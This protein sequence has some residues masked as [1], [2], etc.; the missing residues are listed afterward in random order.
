MSLPASSCRPTRSSSSSRRSRSPA[1]RRGDAKRRRRRAPTRSSPPSPRTDLFNPN[2]IRASAG[3][4]FTRPARGRADAGRDRLAARATASAIVAARVEAPTLYTEADLRGPVAIVLGAE[5]DG[6]TEAWHGAATSSRSH[7]RC[8]AS[9]TAST[10]RSAPRSCS[11]RPA[12]SAGSRPPSIPR[13]TDTLDPFDFVIIGAGPGG[14]AAA[15]KARELGAS[16]AIVDR[17]WFGGSCPHIGCMPSK[18]LLDGAARHHANAAPL[19]LAAA[20][21]ER[22]YM[23]NRAPDAE[24]PD[25]T[26]HWRALRGRGGRLPRRRADRCPGWRRGASRRYQP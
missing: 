24:E 25:D 12:A 15:Y 13:E 14:E 7:C 22:D 21:R 16:V 3:T 11:T 20:S 18:S 19:R 23:V 6:L 10:S 26:G 2:A 9:P 1:S 4:V 5:A 17:G 8:S